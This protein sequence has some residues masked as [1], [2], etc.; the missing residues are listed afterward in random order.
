MSLV[1]GGKAEVSAV[2][3]V[4]RR[5]VAARRE[6]DHMVTSHWQGSEANGQC[7]VWRVAL[8]ARDRYNGGDVLPTRGREHG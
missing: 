8:G 6:G 5:D 3:T 4:S 7:L 1:G 2:T